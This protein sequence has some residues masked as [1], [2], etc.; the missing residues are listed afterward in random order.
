MVDSAVEFRECQAP[1][2]LVRGFDLFVHADQSLHV[3]ALYLRTSTGNSDYP[4][5]CY[6]WPLTSL[7]R[8]EVKTLARSLPVVNPFALDSSYF[9]K[10]R[11]SFLTVVALFALRIASHGSLFTFVGRIRFTIS[12]SFSRLPW[13]PQSS[14]NRPGLRK[15]PA[16]GLQSRNFDVS[17]FCPWQR[18]KHD[19]NGHWPTFC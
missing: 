13:W 1:F 4:Q 7:H 11:I 2:S 10:L 12:S 17:R 3:I 15:L 8:G 14:S 16:G 9:L 19:S 18:D 6:I 5:G